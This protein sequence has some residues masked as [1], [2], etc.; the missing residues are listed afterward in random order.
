MSASVALTVEALAARAA[1][2]VVE[3]DL[4]QSDR[5]ARRLLTRVDPNDVE[6]D[7]VRE[8]LR[9]LQL[10]LYGQ[11]VDDGDD[12][13]IEDA[14]RLFFGA[15]AANGEDARRAWKLTLFALLQD[16]RMVY[17]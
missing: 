4:M 2:A 11:F 6:A 15:L 13:D 8:Q 1:D 7:A 10:R 5:S 12:D 14:M 9:E 17:Y 16:A 3:A